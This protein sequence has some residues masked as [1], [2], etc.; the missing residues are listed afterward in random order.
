MFHALAE[1]RILKTGR[2]YQINRTC[3]QFTQ[4]FTQG[5]IN[6]RILSGW[7]FTQI[8]Q[9]IQVIRDVAARC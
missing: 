6:T 5:E 2:C 4:S 7:T 9:K 1:I 8:D 3:E